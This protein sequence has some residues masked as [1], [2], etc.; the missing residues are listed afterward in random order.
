MTDIQKL[1]NDPKLGF[2]SFTSTLPSISM[3]PGQP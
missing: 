2:G 1:V 3:T